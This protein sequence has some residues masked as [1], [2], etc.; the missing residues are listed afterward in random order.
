L[1]DLADVN[2]DNPRIGDVIKYTALGWRN[3]QDATGGGAGGNACGSNDDFLRRD[4][5]E[6][7]TGTYVW[8]GEDGESKVIVNS[9]T[10]TTQL[11]GGSIIFTDKAQAES[12]RIQITNTTNDLI[13]R[14]N[15]KLLFN[16][17][18]Q[19]QP[20][21]LAELVACCDGGGSGGGTG[22]NVFAPIIRNFT[23]DIAACN[24]D[25]TVPGG[26]GVD[27][28]GQE[29]TVIYGKNWTNTVNTY[30][31][32]GRIFGA[33]ST[34]TK[35][36]N[37]PDG[38][39]AAI[40]FMQNS[41]ELGAWNDPELQADGSQR[42]LHCAQRCE[43][44]NATLPINPNNNDKVGFGEVVKSIVNIPGNTSDI[45]EE[46]TNSK[47][48]DKFDLINFTNQAQVSFKLR[49]DILKGGRGSFRARSGRIVVIPFYSPNPTEYNLPFA[50]GFS[51]GVNEDLVAYYD[52]VSP[53]ET[54]EET[55]MIAG[56]EYRDL[57]RR[58]LVSLES[59]KSYPP[60]GGATEAEFD[61]QIQAAWE[62]VD[63]STLQTLEEFD[64]AL[65]VYYT[66]I[67]KEKYGINF[68]F[69]YEQEA[70]STVRG[71]I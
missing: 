41:V 11:T 1:N 64:A 45:V 8:N 40:V 55:A 3:G 12:G 24:S 39:N 22:G 44:T 26:F 37:M 25:G 30:G 2:I 6:Q 53:R 61:T 33:I 58:I 7:I 62:L 38:A 17:S 9:P 19:E 56:M 47:S 48:F 27:E 71:L 32:D 50:D 57:L 18:T 5:N 28:N 59:R 21:S 63:N 70:G 20:V 35:S 46:Y 34:N 43:V 4:L 60:V 10:E 16:D 42:V 49:L 14:S 52:E 69:Q 66:E 13:L 67:T 15:N 29:G 36:I 51:V 54:P 23:I 31:E 65:K 68:L